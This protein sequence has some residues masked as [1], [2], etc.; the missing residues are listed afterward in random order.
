MHDPTT[1][2]NDEQFVEDVQARKAKAESHL[3]TDSGERL[4]I[5][6]LEEIYMDAMA[7]RRAHQNMTRNL[8]GRTGEYNDY[9]ELRRPFGDNQ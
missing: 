1:V 9:L 8:R 5:E 7:D 4:A 2:K 3:D 6:D